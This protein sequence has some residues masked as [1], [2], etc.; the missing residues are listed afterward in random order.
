LVFCNEL[1]AELFDVVVRPK[2]R[3]F[4]TDEDRTLIYEIIERYAIYIPV[5]SSITLCRDA[6]DNFLLS[7]ATDSQ[8]DYLLTGDK[9]LLV[10]KTIGITQIVTIAEFQTIIDL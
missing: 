9:D 5:V 3:K 10:L 6:K 8:A 1:L 7:L 4:F 2:L